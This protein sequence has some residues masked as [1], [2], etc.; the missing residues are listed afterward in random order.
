MVTV[1][2]TFTRVT[3][4]VAV[5]P[6]PVDVLAPV[7]EAGAAPGQAVV[8]RRGAGR[9]LDALVGEGEH[10]GLLG[11]VSPAHGDRG[12]AGAGGGGQDDDQEEQGED[13]ETRGRQ[14]VDT[15]LVEVTG[16]DL[17][18]P[19]LILPLPQFV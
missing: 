18:K 5:S 11:G 15:L 19:R 12:G 4:E 3:V 6:P 16:V 1:T 17:D 10:A 14:D 13:G 7:V 2:L 9:V 8:V